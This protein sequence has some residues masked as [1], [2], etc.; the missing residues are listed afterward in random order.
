MSRKYAER[1][2]RSV[3][4]AGLVG[5]FALTAGVKADIVLHPGTVSGTA[6]LTNWTFDSGSIYVGGNANGFSGSTSI[7]AA[8]SYSLT[9]EGGQTY[10]SLS[11]NFTQYNPYT[12]FSMSRTTTLPVPVGGVAANED[13]LTPGGSVRVNFSATTAPGASA[14]VSNVYTYAYAS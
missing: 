9:V 12:N 13:L 2:R 5:L 6:G 10:G 14:A 3:V 11:E 8:G 1:A 7:G 4:A